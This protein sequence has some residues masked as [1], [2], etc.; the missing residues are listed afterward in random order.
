M[1]KF[2]AAVT[3]LT[4]GGTG[5]VVGGRTSALQGEYMKFIYKSSVHAWY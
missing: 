1:V 5:T 4:Y 2:T 3:T